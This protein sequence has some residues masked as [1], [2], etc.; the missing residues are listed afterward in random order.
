MLELINSII[1]N[2]N[3]KDYFSIIKGLR[4]GIIYGIKIRFPHALVMTFLF[5]KKR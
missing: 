3:Y 1:N 2:P 4:N 5:N